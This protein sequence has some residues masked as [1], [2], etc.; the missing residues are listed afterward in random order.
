MCDNTYMS[1]A[2]RIWIQKKI[3]ELHFVDLSL[4]MGLR[5]AAVSADAGAGLC[6]GLAPTP[7]C[8]NSV[9]I[10]WAGHP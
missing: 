3:E 4:R 8:A 9:R 5:L 2:T 1:V 7:R 6:V 10:R